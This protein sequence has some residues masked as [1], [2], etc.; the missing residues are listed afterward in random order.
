MV[1]KEDISRALQSQK[2]QFKKN[3][4]GFEREILPQIDLNS[5]HILVVSGIRRCGKSTLLHQISKKINK[6]SDS[7]FFNFEDFRLFGFE[8]N[9]FSKLEE[10]LDPNPNNYFFDEIQNVDNWEVYI[11]NLHDQNKK[12][13][14]TGSNASMLSKELGTRLTGRYI[15]IELFPFSYKEFRGFKKMDKNLDSVRK[16]LEIGGFPEYIIESKKENL[17]QLLKDILYRDIIVRNGIRSSQTFVEI[18][19]YLLSNIGKEY[20]LNNIK[21][22]FRVGSAN[23]VADYVQWLEDAYVIFSLPRFS[24]SLKKVAV[25]PRKVYAI[26]T[27]FAK[28][29]TLSYT[30]DE[31]RLLENLVFLQLRRKYPEIFYFREKGECDFVVKEGRKITLAIQVS[32]SINQDNMK[33]ELDGLL[34]ALKAFDLEKGIIVTMDQKDTV[35]KEDKTIALIPVWEWLD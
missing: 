23:S 5:N 1:L 16:Y 11:R 9:D 21:K 14:L 35:L 22:I 19:Q 13:Y 29:N 6:E 12:I 30:K 31:G 25:N 26:D 15:Q 18:A 17:Q 8:L 20:S 24:W 32:Q 4:L 2:S 3:A 34:E 10:L 28:A 7:L 27:G 33:R